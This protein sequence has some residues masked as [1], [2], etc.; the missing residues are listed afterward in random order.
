MKRRPLNS[1]A[2]IGLAV[3]L[4]CFWIAE[5]SQ[6]NVD[7]FR[8]GMAVLGVV[9]GLIAWRSLRKYGWVIRRERA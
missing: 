4:E 1:V 3:M 5:T 2:M 7:G 9:F 8:F 6:E